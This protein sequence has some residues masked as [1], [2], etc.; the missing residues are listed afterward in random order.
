[1][2]RERWPLDPADVGRRSAARMEAA[3]RGR[4]DR[5]RHLSLEDDALAAD[6]FLDFAEDIGQFVFLLEA[7]DAP[8]A[9]TARDD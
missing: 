6:L 4:R 1:V 3:A 7:A 2:I 8:K 5:A 9:L